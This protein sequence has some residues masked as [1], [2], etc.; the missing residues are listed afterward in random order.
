MATKKEFYDITKILAERK[1]DQTWTELCRDIG[2]DENWL[3]LALKE[4]RGFELVWEDV[5]LS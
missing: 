4:A 3:S 2:S 5:N 1:K